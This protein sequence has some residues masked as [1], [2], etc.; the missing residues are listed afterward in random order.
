MGTEDT[1]ALADIN[2]D[3]TL[4]IRDVDSG[5]VSR[6]VDSLEAGEQLP[7]LIIEA[8]TN[9]LVDGFHRYR[10]CERVGVE[11]VTVEKRRYSNEAELFAD[12]VRLNAAHGRSLTSY[13]IRRIT[14]R[15]QKYGF[16]VQQ[17]AEMLRI[18][19]EAIERRQ[20]AG[21]VVRRGQATETVPLKRTFQKLAGKTLTRQQVEANKR[22]GGMQPLFYVNQVI[23][24]LE[25]DAVD[26]S[27]EV[28]ASRLAHLREL[29][30]GLDQLTTR[31]AA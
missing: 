14:E 15:A 24:C 5:H 29:L 25:A 8:V 23:N 2:A 18:K 6:L 27:N 1:V 4:A 9:R 22:A 7:P 12:A 3:W 31:S 17:V 19:P 10:A 21:Q 26:L 11:T 28:M 20:L 16:K 30:D 13:D